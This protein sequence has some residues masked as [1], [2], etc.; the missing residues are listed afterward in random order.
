MHN[1]WAI[2][3]DSHTPRDLPA[4]SSAGPSPT[5]APTRKYA[6]NER[7]RGLGSHHHHHC[8]WGCT[9]HVRALRVHQLSRH[10]LALGRR[11]GMLGRRRV[12]SRRHL[13]GQAG[14]GTG[15]QAVGGSGRN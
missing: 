6:H 9:R 15:E 11:V 2:G 14:Q 8:A 10:L 4:H 5:V 13:G 12:L 7:P 1:A 3:C